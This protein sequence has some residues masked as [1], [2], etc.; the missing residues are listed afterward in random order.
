M[1]TAIQTMVVG[2]VIVIGGA[3]SLGAQET[4]A[5]YTT[6]QINIGTKPA[7]SGSCAIQTQLGGTGAGSFV[8][9][10]ICAAAAGGLIFTFSGTGGVNAPSGWSCRV[11]DLTT[12]ADAVN[13][14]AYTAT[15][16]TFTATWA[17]SDLITYQCSPF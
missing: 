4:I 3:L 8:G 7:N 13:Q 17:A 5:R 10:G 12:T 16:A 11:S 15:T 1:R 14:T 2:S 9:T 6:A